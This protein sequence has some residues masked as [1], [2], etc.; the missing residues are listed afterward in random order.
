MHLVP[1]QVVTARLR[2]PE[3]VTG[4]HFEHS[5]TYFTACGAGSAAHHCLLPPARTL[6]LREATRSG[7]IIHLTP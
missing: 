7:L 5:Y 2:Q 4:R 3:V 1:A 6:R